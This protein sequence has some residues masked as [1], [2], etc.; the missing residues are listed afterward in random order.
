M[1]ACIKEVEIAGKEATAKSGDFYGRGMNNLME[2]SAEYFLENHDWERRIF[3][4]KLHDAG[5]KTD[6]YKA[7]YYWQVSKTHTDGSKVEV[8]YIEGDIYVKKI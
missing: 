7:P 5:F 3:K 1:L 8:K 6:W 2:K 4:A